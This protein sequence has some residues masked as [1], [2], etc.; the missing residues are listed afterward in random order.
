MACDVCLE[1]CFV[2]L[3]DLC[4]AP[5]HSFHIYG[6]WTSRSNKVWL[7]LRNPQLR[8]VMQVTKGCSFEMKG[9]FSL[10]NT[11]VLQI[12]LGIYCKKF[13]WIPYFTI[14][15]F[16][17]FEVGNAKSATQCSKCPN[18]INT[19]FCILNRPSSPCFFFFSL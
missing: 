3:V 1:V 10:C 15:L 17:V 11:T 7:M 12:L 9:R 18:D 2:G 13:Y 4:M 19:K 16:Y 8:V 14:L 6:I 5:C